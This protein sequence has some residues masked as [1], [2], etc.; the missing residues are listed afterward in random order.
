MHLLLKLRW[1]ADASSMCMRTVEDR[2]CMTEFAFVDRGARVA[3]RGLLTL[4][5]GTL[6]IAS[7]AGTGGEAMDRSAKKHCTTRSAICSVPPL[8][9]QRRAALANRTIAGVGSNET[10]LAELL[11]D[12]AEGVLQDGQRKDILRHAHNWTHRLLT[13][14]W[15]NPQRL[16]IVAVECTD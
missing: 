15:A 2:G 1:A 11:D 5:C 12:D 8:L 4:S 6:L 10:R 7:A 3:I 13:P 9:V 14:G 16:L